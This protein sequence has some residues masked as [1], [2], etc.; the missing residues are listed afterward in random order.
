VTAPQ[1]RSF[2]LDPRGI[3]AA[4]EW[5]AAVGEEWRCDE[6]TTFAARLCVA[7]LAGNALEHGIPTADADRFTVTL[8]RHGDG[9]RIEV[10]D[11][12]AP[13]DPSSVAPATAAA[14]IE[15]AAIGG[16]GLVLVRAY[17][18]SLAYR[19]DGAHNR[20][21]LRIAARQPAPA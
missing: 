6:R 3:G 19:H 13:F 20:V 14:S 2:A 15:D 7:E 8:D 9:I 10:I 12:R 11:S 18:Q 21:T 17:A 5:I 16:R 1:T 4:D